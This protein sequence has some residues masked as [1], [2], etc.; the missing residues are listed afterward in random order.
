MGRLVFWA[1][2]LGRGLCAL[3]RIWVWPNLKYSWNIQKTSNK[4]WFGFCRFSDKNFKK[5]K[6][7]KVMM[8]S[9][10]EDLLLGHGLDDFGRPCTNQCH[11]K[12]RLVL[13]FFYAE[14]REPGWTETPGSMPSSS[15][16]AA[17]GHA[18]FQLSQLEP[19]PFWPPPCP[20]LPPRWINRAGMVWNAGIDAIF[21]ASGRTPSWSIRLRLTC[22]DLTVYYIELRVIL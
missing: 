20:P 15:P 3:G 21:L 10:M 12:L 13:L 14:A 17:G 8:I 7:D 11:R 16:L 2:A 5:I 4:Y 6:E 18:R 22:T 1:V 9:S 19:V